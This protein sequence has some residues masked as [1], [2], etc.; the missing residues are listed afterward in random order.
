[1]PLSL[2]QA[3]DADP[4]A[5]LEKGLPL[6]L[7]KLKELRPNMN[8]Q[9]KIWCKNA[10]DFAS[11]AVQFI[12]SGEAQE[13]AYASMKALQA[14][15]LIE[16]S[17][18]AKPRIQKALAAQKRNEINAEKSMQQRKTLNSS[19]NAFIKKLYKNVPERF[20]ENE[21]A[22]ARNIKKQAQKLPVDTLYAD[23]ISSL[24]ER[25]IINIIKNWKLAP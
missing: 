16:T 25:Q 2:V 8:E 24:S 14:A 20:K 5:W 17:I 11:L 4:L 23:K 13:G 10:S 1:M 12:K 9:E 22:A 21:S 3:V 19:R 15:W 7:E 18:G 6:R